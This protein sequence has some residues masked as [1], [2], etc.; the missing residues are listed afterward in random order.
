MVPSSSIVV[1][2]DDECLT[3]GGFSLRKPVCL[4]NFEFI[5]DYFDDLSLSHKR[6]NEGTIFMGSTHSRASTLQRDTIEDSTEVFLTM[7]SE[8]GSFG[9]PSPKWCSTGALCPQYNNTEGERSSH[10]EVSPADDGTAVGKQPPLRAT[11]QSPQ[12]TTR[13]SPCSASP[14]RAGIGATMKQPHR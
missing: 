5:A 2:V 11:P 12:R 9:H 3:C 14:L 13:A 1:A 6:G 10:D 4:G 7:L 8:E